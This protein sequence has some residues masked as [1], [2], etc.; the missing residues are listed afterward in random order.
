MQ[1]IQEY[2]Y[3]HEEQAF[4][5]KAFLTIFLIIL[6]KTYLSGLVL[7]PQNDKS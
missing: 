6:A 2:F 5:A 1:A 4:I 3:R 7:S